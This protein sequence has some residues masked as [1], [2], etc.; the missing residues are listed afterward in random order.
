[1]HALPIDEPLGVPDTLE[2]ACNPLLEVCTAAN[3]V[4]GGAETGESLSTLFD[5]FRSLSGANRVARD[6]LTAGPG[7]G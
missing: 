1:V 7:S 5:E 4:L 6:E 2:L 3:R